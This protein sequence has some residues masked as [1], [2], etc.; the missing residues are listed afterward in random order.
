MVE[1]KTSSNILTST[2][3][4]GR[5][6]RRPFCRE[7]PESF[8]VEQTWC[9]WEQR[10]QSRWGNKVPKDVTGLTLDIEHCTHSQPLSLQLSLTCASSTLCANTLSQVVRRCGPVSAKDKGMTSPRE[11]GS[12][13]RTCSCRAAQWREGT[14][15][16][17]GEEQSPDR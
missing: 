17:S 9:V 7:E 2:V 14:T 10:E 8:D 6:R 5:L 12:L 13:T 16:Y 1:W 11:L 3:L 4:Y 15:F